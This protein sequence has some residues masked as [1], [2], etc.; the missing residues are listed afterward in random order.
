MYNKAL[1]LGVVKMKQNEKYR[2]KSYFGFEL[3]CHLEGSPDKDHPKVCQTCGGHEI[4]TQSVGPRELIVCSV[5]RGMNDLNPPHVYFREWECVNVNNEV[6]WYKAVADGRLADFHWTCAIDVDLA[7]NSEDAPNGRM[8]YKKGTWHLM[9]DLIAPSTFLR[10]GWEQYHPD[11]SIA[12]YV[13]AKGRNASKAMSQAE[14]RVQSQRQGAM[15]EL[16]KGSR[17][18]SRTP[19]YMTPT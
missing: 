12:I 7:S 2:S 15:T 11:R 14:L 19:V 9:N 3:M 1:A 18:K 10:V 4:N 13:R 6:V 8:E 5:E 17:H 16:I